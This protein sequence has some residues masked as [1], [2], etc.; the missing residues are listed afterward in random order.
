MISVQDPDPISLW[1]ALEEQD[2]TIERAWH[3]PFYLRALQERN[4]LV[5]RWAAAI[6]TVPQ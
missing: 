6:H 1:H 4:R 2:E 3:T 5:Q